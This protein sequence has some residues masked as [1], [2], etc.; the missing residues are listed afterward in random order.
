MN[1]KYYGEWNDFPDNNRM[2]VE[3]YIDSAVTV[4]EQITVREC[5]ESRPTLSPFS[6]DSL[7]GTILSLTIVS[8]SRLYYKDSFYLANMKGMLVKFFV[9]Y[10]Q[11]GQKLAFVGYVNSEIY[12]DSFSDTKN[13]DI[14]IKANNGISLLER[15]LLLDEENEIYSG[16]LLNIDLLKHCLAQLEIPYSFIYIS[17][18]STVHAVGANETLFHKVSSKAEN[19]YDETN[20]P[21]S[22]KEILAGMM[23]AN[24]CKLYIF[25]NSIYI[26][27]ISLLNKAPITAKKYSFSSLAYIGT[28]QIKSEHVVLDQLGTGHGLYMTPAKNKINIVFNKYVNSQEESI[29][30]TAENVSDPSGKQAFY[31]AEDNFQ[32]YEQKYMTCANVDRL[33]GDS[34]PGTEFVLKT[35]SDGNPMESFMRIP[36]SI[37]GAY[38][39]RLHS[40]RI[41][42]SSDMFIGI[43][44]MFQFENPDDIGVE[45]FIGWWMPFFFRPV[46]L[47]VEGT[48]DWGFSMDGISE[49]PS[50]IYHIG[51]SIYTIVEG[52]DRTPGSDFYERKWAPSIPTVPVAALAVPP[53][54]YNAWQEFNGGALKYSMGRASSYQYIGGGG[55]TFEKHNCLYKWGIVI[56]LANFYK[57]R[58]EAPEGGMFALDI[59]IP[60]SSDFYRWKNLLLKDMRISAVKE[61]D[62]NLFKKVDDADSMY[63]VTGDIRHK[64]EYSIETTQ[65]TDNL[66]LARGTYVLKTEGVFNNTLATNERYVNLDKIA[67]L[68]DINVSSNVYN[69]IGANDDIYVIKELDDG[70][71]VIGGKFTSYGGVSVVGKIRMLIL[72]P[73]GTVSSFVPPTVSDGQIVTCIDYDYQEIFVGTEDGRLHRIDRSPFSL[74]HTIVFNDKINVV[75]VTK[76]DSAGGFV[77]VGGRFTSYIDADSVTKTAKAIAK[78]SKSWFTDHAHIGHL[79][80]KLPGIPAEVHTIIEHPQ[81]GMEGS[82]YFIGGFFTH[83]LEPTIISR[84]VDDTSKNYEIWGMVCVDAVWG[85]LPNARIYNQG[86]VWDA[87]SAGGVPTDYTQKGFW[88]DGASMVIQEMFGTVYSITKGNSGDYDLY[89]VGEFRGYGETST[90]NIARI[91]LPSGALALS[92]SLIFPARKIKISPNN[93]LF[94]S[95]FNESAKKDIIAEYNVQL[96][97]LP[98]STACAFNTNSIIYDFVFLGPSS[99]LLGGH[100]ST[101]HGYPFSNVLALSMQSVPIGMG[102]AIT[103]M[104]Y[105]CLELYHAQLKQ[106]RYVFTN[107]EMRQ[108]PKPFQSFSYGLLQRQ[109]VDSIF[110]MNKMEI[111]YVHGVTSADLEEII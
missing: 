69:S 84:G 41:V 3:F 73:N 59:Y 45:S 37:G 60:S 93:T 98:F 77:V 39:V 62:F 57:N 6:E 7:F 99:V 28:E 42:L 51:Q 23:F 67:Y 5:K 24:L 47:G 9:N 79:T 65:G 88:G 96:E 101:Y 48:Q 15:M 19:F 1:L 105:I 64:D 76:K 70:T 87:P 13:Y 89:V 108:Y 90:Q 21:T 36:P 111:D 109:A 44:G 26:I 2:R 14:Y 17:S 61:V 25:D 74:F 11:T 33:S 34:Y 10:G 38:K 49:V 103:S 107:V 110:V 32:Y 53:Q 52:S 68:Y 29:G 102:G 46:I 82:V 72:N 80:F 100:F 83:Y 55:N 85:M 104:E 22:L 18:L 54:K 16:L 20:A 81:L 40:K 66:G 58:T 92:G 8:P 12:E 91:A 56:P 94:I 50:A 97:R 75:F 30:V 71:I 43:E 31:D 95:G 106:P 27:D 86:T 35:D 78:L 63:Q 4:V